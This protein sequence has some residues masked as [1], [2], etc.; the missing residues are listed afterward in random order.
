M[1]TLLVE[2]PPRVW[3]RPLEVI[4]HLAELRNTPTGVGKTV[5]AGL[6]FWASQK[7]PHG[8]GEDVRELNR[9]NAELETPPRVWGRPAGS[10]RSGRRP[11][12]TPTGVGK[13]AVTRM[14]EMH[15]GKHPHGC[16][17]DAGAMNIFA[18]IIETPPRVWG[19]HVWRVWPP[20]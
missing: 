11:G 18:F 1:L 6:E 3:G 13:T 5:W 4:A 2:T 9:Q 20:Y 12:N 16:G 10:Y 7:H 8:C 17:E 15:P 14:C 19:R